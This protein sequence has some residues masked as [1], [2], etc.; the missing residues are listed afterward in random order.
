V[1]GFAFFVNMRIV[2]MIGF[3]CN[4]YNTQNVNNI[5]KNDIFVE[6]S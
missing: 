3:V 2:K 4:Y 5:A 6:N 1:G